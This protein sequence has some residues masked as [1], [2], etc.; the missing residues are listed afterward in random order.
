[1]SS[2]KF[3]FR[4]L[5]S[6]FGTRRLPLVFVMRRGKLPSGF[7]K[8]CGKVEVKYSEL[9]VCRKIF[10]VCYSFFFPPW[11]LKNTLFPAFIVFSR[12]SLFVRVHFFFHHNCEFFFI[13]INLI[14]QRGYHSMEI[15]GGP[16]ERSLE[17]T[18]RG[19]ERTNHCD[20]CAK[21]GEWASSSGWEMSRV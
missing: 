5:L 3:H 6:Q 8:I 15:I 17:C 16:V 10:R 13:D 14:V 12:T 7:C 1:M 9:F 11:I 19:R 20:T 4:Q 2:L 18:N 21:E